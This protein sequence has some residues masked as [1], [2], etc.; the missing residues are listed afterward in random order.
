MW[1]RTSPIESMTLQ[2]FVHPSFAN[3][4]PHVLT[5]DEAISRVGAEYD[6]TY[7]Y[8]GIVQSDM[9][10]AMRES[11]PGLIGDPRYQFFRE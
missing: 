5:R 1:N 3:L 4:K 6:P 10:R 2:Q 7:E 8:T 9:E 11:L